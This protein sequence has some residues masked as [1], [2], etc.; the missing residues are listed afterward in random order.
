MHARLITGYIENNGKIHS[1]IYSDSWGEK[2]LNKKMTIQSAFKMTQNDGMRIIYP[3]D[4]DPQ[5]IDSI[6]P[7]T[8]IIE[9]ITK[10]AEVQKS[11]DTV[12]TEKKPIRPYYKNPPPSWARD[13]D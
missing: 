12:S 9:P 7:K 6:I 8:A 11:Q 10:K 4:L 1:I 3:K 5:I 13:R 2:H